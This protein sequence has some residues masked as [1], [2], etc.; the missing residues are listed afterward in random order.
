[1]QKAFSDRLKA[2]AKAATGSSN[3]IFRALLLEELPSIDKGE[4]TDKGSINQRAVIRHRASK[5]EALYH[6]PPAA[7]IISLS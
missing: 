4:I 1:M 5:V 3:R 2:F 7:R 6:E